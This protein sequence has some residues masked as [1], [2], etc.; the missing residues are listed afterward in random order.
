MTLDHNGMKLMLP[1]ILLMACADIKSTGK[2][3]GGNDAFIE[4]YRGVS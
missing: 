1:F 2:Q 3:I 4:A